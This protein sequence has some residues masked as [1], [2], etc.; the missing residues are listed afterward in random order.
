MIPFQ[1][2]TI[3]QPSLELHKPAAALPALDLTDKRRLFLATRIDIYT[4]SI[5]AVPTSA[6]QRHPL[7]VNAHILSGAGLALFQRGRLFFG[8]SCP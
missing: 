2:Q 1:K 5:S 7:R 4:G 3:G 8:L 6:T